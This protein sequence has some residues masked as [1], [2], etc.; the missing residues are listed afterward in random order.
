MDEKDI[1]GIA[2]VIDD[3]IGDEYVNITKILDQLE[4]KYIPCIKLQSIPADE[5]LENLHGISFLI[6]DWDLAGGAIDIEQLQ[7]GVRLPD[8]VKEADQEKTM[9]FIDYIKDKC[10]APIFIL[11]NHSPDDIVPKL[12]D[13]NIIVDGKPNF[14]FVKSKS[15]VVSGELLSEIVTWIKGNPSVYVLSEWEREYFKAKN[16]MFSDFYNMSPGWSKV[17]WE[18]FAIDGVNKSLSIGNVIG[19]NLQSR[20]SPYE[21]DGDVFDS[22]EYSANKEETRSVIQGE[23]FVMSSELHDD[24]TTT[25]DVFC[26]DKKIFLNIRPECDCVP[27]RQNDGADVDLYLI[28]GSPISHPKEQ[29]L[30]DSMRGLIQEKEVSATIFCMYKNKSYEFFFKNLQ[31]VKWL[32]VKEKRVGRLLPPYITRI[33]QRYSHYL[34]RQ[35]MPRIPNIAVQ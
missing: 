19:R 34:Q 25:G 4:K 6:L 9:Q 29:T 2:I 5:Y 11:T 14:V 32:D 1:K 27:G 12:K 15:E 35:G 22:C 31:I 7:Q 20:M 8:T 16:K 21:F 17:L 13:K 23:R 3:Q 24:S 26:I 33:Q 28:K 18:T 10:F 30:F